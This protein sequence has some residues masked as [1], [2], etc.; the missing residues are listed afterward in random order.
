MWWLDTE[1]D[2]EYI[3]PLYATYGNMICYVV[4]VIYMT[5][6]LAIRYI[7]IYIYTDTNYTTRH[8]HYII[9]QHILRRVLYKLH[10]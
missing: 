8:T 7:Y 2:F 1:A 5:S 4:E 3:T 6:N 9:I 10:A